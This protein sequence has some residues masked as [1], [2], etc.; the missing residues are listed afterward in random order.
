MMPVLQLGGLALPTKPLLLLLGFYVALWI[1]GK[2]VMT[3]DIDEDVAWNWGIVSVLS[4]LVIGRL[5]HVALYPRAYLDAPLSLL[6]PRLTGFVP[7]AFIVGGLLAGFLY[8]YRRRV[9]LPKFIDGITPGLVVGWAFYALA[10]FLAG[11][12]YGAP[13]SV[14]WAVEM[15]GALRHPT[16]LYEMVAA[17]L[18]LL[19]LFA[20]PVPR[21]QGL[22]GWRL[23]FGY[24]LSRLIIEGFRGDSVLLAGGI[25]AYQIVALIL[26]LVALWGLSRHAP[27]ASDL[28]EGNL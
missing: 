15:W 23:L 17:L 19:W 22:W 25:R 2:G 8:L 14:P 27:R 1:G 7:E 11:D 24:S 13:T 26:A 20:R 18:T 4:G 6:T 5:T 21:G 12:A 28:Q 3:L 16:Q 9:P 10:N